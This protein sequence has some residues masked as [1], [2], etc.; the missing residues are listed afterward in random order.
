MSLRGLKVYVFLLF[1]VLLSFSVLSFSIINVPNKNMKTLDTIKVSPPYA[2]YEYSP[3]ID[4][5]IK[6]MSVSQ[7]IAQLIMLPVYPSKSE[8]LFNNTLDTISK[9]GIGGIIVFKGLPYKTAKMIAT[10]QKKNKIPLLVAIDGEW[11]VSMRLD[12]TVKFPKQ[13][14]LGAV[15]NNFLIYKMGQEI[16]RECKM[17]GVNIN[18]APVIDININP[19]NIIIGY[20]SFGDDKYNVAVKGYYYYRGLQDNK[21]LAVAKH[22]PG[23]GDT[24]K[25]SHKTLPTILHSKQKIFNE[26]LY[27]FKYLIYTGVGGVMVAHLHIP[28][29][30]S[31]PNL[32]STLSKKIVKGV[33]FD[34]LDFKGVAFTDALNMKGVAAYWD[35]VTINIKALEAGNTILL[36]P[37]DIGK[38]IKVLE[39]K[40]KSGEISENELNKRVRKVLA[41]KKWTG[42]LDKKSFGVLPPDVLHKRLVSDTVLALK[43]KLINCAITLVKNK[44]D[45]LPIKRLQGKKVLILNFAKQ[46]DVASEFNKYMLRYKYADTVTISFDKVR[47]AKLPNFDNYDYVFVSL[48]APS[49]RPKSNYG[50]VSNVFDIISNINADNAVFT[51]FGSPYLLNNL[52]LNNYKSVVVAYDQEDAIQRVVPQKIY[53]AYGFSGLLS[54]SAG[55]FVSGTSITT[56]A[57]G[58][59]KYGYPSEV[60]LNSDTLVLI[61]DIAKE[62]IRDGAYPG[63]QILVAKNGVVVYQKSFGHFTYDTTSQNVNN[64]TLYDLASITK[65]AS[66]TL[67]LMK[68]Y[69]NKKFLLNDKLSQYLP[70]LDTT[71]KKDITFLEVLTHQAGLIPW[72]PFY[73]HLIKNKAAYDTVISNKKTEKYSITICDSMYMDSA[74]IH[75][76]YRE[77][78]LSPMHKKEYKYSDVGFYLFKLFI[79]EQTGEP[80]YK[81]VEKNFYSPLG[82]DYT[83]Y[84][85]LRHFGKTDIAPTE[86]DH[87]FR[88]RL[89]HGYVHDYGAAMLGGVGGHAGLFSNANDLAKI[90]QMLLNGGSYAGTRYFSD[91]TIKRFTS[92]PFAP[93]NRRGIGFDKPEKRPNK[94]GPTCAEA[95]KSSFGHTGF[96]GTMVWADPKNQLIYVFL[97]NRVYPTAENKKIIRENIRTR[98]QSVIYRSIVTRRNER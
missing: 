79:E 10:V 88:H 2:K 84:N 4:S 59:L 87:Y 68:L 28:A 38:T 46:K 34:S 40:I 73:L 65:V 85:P 72:I 64:F 39:Q 35:A 67:S 90:M 66:T 55:D 3:Q 82:A 20:R 6:G 24:E 95:P 43:Q 69:E 29:L 19:K 32:A 97:S 92:C 77:I 60:G 54:V 74:Y 1:I 48:F 42:L 50:V 11:G 57:I 17:L 47:S 75:T 21:V 52:R 37:K 91:T 61:D 49:V 7:K 98:I 26:D 62:G 33:L 22:F 93:N 18:F 45:L 8:K 86:D 41:I 70:F 51:L 80:L 13:I 23:H 5:I 14:M 16:A 31:T 9:Y 53:G 12:S 36:M 63:A 15:R 78:A 71:N 58:R 89:V 94:I 25:D 81:Y 76:M 83:L 56:K 27:P 44:D 96:T 30:D